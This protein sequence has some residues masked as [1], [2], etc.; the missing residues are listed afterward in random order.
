MLRHLLLPLL[1]ASSLFA[2]KINIV[3]D[4]SYT[5]QATIYDRDQSELASFLLGKGQSTMWFDSLYNAKDYVK[6]PFSVTFTCPTGANFGT[7]YRLRENSTARARAARGP[8]KCTAKSQ[9]PP[10]RDWEENL[11][12]YKY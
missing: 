10:H 8:K 3:N 7:V 6:G 9:P 5:L 12:T 1:F 11:P 4:S 2:V